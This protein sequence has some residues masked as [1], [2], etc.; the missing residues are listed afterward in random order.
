MKGLHSHITSSQGQSIEQF[1]QYLKITNA[2]KM[3]ENKHGKREL[4]IGKWAKV[5]VVE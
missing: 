1:G 5:E 2:W 4:H 3:Q